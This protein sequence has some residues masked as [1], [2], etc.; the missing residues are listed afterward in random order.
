MVK[1]DDLG[2]PPCKDA[3]EEPD[4]LPAPSSLL[5]TGLGEDDVGLPDQTGLTVGRLLID[6]FVS[7]CSQG[8][9]ECRRNG[10]L[11][12]MGGLLLLLP[13]L[14]LML[15][16]RDCDVAAG[17]SGNAGI[18][19]SGGEEI[20]TMAG[21]EV[22]DDERETGSAFGTGDENS[23]E[24]LAIRRLDFSSRANKDDL[25]PVVPTG[26]LPDR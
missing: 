9:L 7:G 19:V 15:L 22:T 11:P 26:V 8:T 17:V 25:F 3:E 1:E 21:S 24:P 6:L 12:G 5:T 14:L 4:R 2:E 20:A 18:G 16:L 10:D 23:S 13:A